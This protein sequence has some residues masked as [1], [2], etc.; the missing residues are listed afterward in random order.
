MSFHGN[1]LSKCNRINPYLFSVMLN[2]TCKL[3]SFNLSISLTMKKGSGD[4]M[5]FCW[6]I[7][8]LKFLW[9]SSI[10]HQFWLGFYFQDI[11]FNGFHAGNSFNSIAVEYLAFFFKNQNYLSLILDTVK[12]DILSEL[13][14]AVYCCKLKTPK[15]LISFI[16]CFSMESMDYLIINKRPRGLDSHLSIIALL[17]YK[18]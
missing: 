16:L 17:E 10:C 3:I 11:V 1:F 14:V 6:E 2:S 5:I 8:T 18:P 9:S 7:K 15:K 13:F 4:C 12:K